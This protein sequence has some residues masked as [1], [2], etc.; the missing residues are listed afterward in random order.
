MV[1]IQIRGLK[2][3]QEVEV[4]KFQMSNST[5]TW[6]DISQ[7]ADS[8]FKGRKWIQDGVK[9]EILSIWIFVSPR[10]IES[11]LHAPIADFKENHAN[12]PE[13]KYYIF[14][15]YAEAILS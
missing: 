7:V 11:I 4:G 9:Y 3:E 10:I 2:E 6:L 8:L 14:K 12:W 15:S 5:L 13:G 1:T